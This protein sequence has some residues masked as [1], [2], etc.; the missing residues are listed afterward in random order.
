M[1]FTLPVFFL[2]LPVVVTLYWL[3]PAKMRWLMLLMASYIFYMYWNPFLVIL[4]LISWVVKLTKRRARGPIRFSIWY[5]Y[6]FAFVEGALL[7]ARTSVIPS[8]KNI[9]SIEACASVAVLVQKRA[10]PKHWSFMGKALL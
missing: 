5:V 6:L 10:L 8:I 1:S 3:L 9:P 7:Y 4:L 2:F